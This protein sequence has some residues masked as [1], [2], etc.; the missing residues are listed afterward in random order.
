MQHGQLGEKKWPFDCLLPGF[1]APLCLHTILLI[2]SPRDEAP[3]HFHGEESLTCFLVAYP[4]PSITT[5]LSLSLP[6]WLAIAQSSHGRCAFGY[7]KP[8]WTGTSV[9]LRPPIEPSQRL[10]GETGPI[11]ESVDTGTPSRSLDTRPPPSLQWLQH[12]LHY[13]AERT[14]AWS[15]SCATLL[16]WVN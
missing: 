1:L 11:M 3:C 15:N 4:P 12:V 14:A 6:F 13:G 5:S 8:E 9:Q 7:K 2:Y 16:S 10:T